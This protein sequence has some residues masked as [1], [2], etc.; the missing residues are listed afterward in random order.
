MR[1]PYGRRAPIYT[2]SYNQLSTLHNYYDQET[3]IK[4]VDLVYSIVYAR[5]FIKK[6]RNSVK[7][8]YSMKDGQTN[9]QKLEKI[10]YNDEPDLVYFSTLFKFLTFNGKNKFWILV[11]LFI[12]SISIFIFSDLW[13]GLWSI[14]FFK[15][16][17]KV[18]YLITYIAIAFGLIIY[19]LLRD[20]VY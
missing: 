2:I 9:E 20:C 15:L 1:K 17:Q 7:R 18:N 12:I 5:I 14:N 4:F 13:L 16:D 6:L 19:L 8:K 11:I 10:D 3:G